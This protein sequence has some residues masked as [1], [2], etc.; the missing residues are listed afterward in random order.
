MNA[1]PA[2]W[3]LTAPEDSDD[4]NSHP[5]AGASATF[6]DGSRI[7]LA[8]LGVDGEGRQRYAYTLTDP[9]GGVVEA[10]QDL[11]SGV[12]HG[13]DHR[14]MLAAWTSFAGA[15]ADTYRSTMDGDVMQ[16]WAYQHDDE[17][18]A[19]SCELEPD[20]D[21]DTGPGAEDDQADSEDDQ[22]GTGPEAQPH[23]AREAHAQ[24]AD[25]AGDDDT[26]GA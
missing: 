17:L 6:R 25:V 4:P 10:G 19:L 13:V 18:A 3:A 7:T 24:P 5:G 23:D 11:R 21:S 22:P 14:R 12:G 9:A 16:E 15:D 20:P 1:E 8:H 26:D 2:G